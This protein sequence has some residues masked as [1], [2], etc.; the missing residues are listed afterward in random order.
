MHTFDRQK[1][2]ATARATLAELQT[3]PDRCGLFATLGDALFAC[4]LGRL[5]PVVDVA[6]TLARAQRVIAAENPG[7]GLHRGLAGLGF[8]LATYC[9]AEPALVEVDAAVLAALPSVPP[10]SLQSGLAGIALYASLRSHAPS[11]RRLQQAVVA[12][13][14][15]AAVRLAGGVVWHT[16]ADYARRRGMNVAAEPVL[17]LGMVHGV[18]GTLVGL[19]ALARCGHDRAAELARAGLRALSALEQSGDNRFG[20]VI[21]G[22]GGAGGTLEL[23]GRWCVGDVG[24]DRAAWLVANAVGEAAAAA[25]A[26]DRLRAHAEA[27]AA[28]GIA[29]DPTRYDLC[30]GRSVVAQV[31]LLMHRETREPIFRRASDR[32]ATV[33]AEKMASVRPPNVIYGRAGILL[34][35]LARDRDDMRWD[36]L[37]GLTL[38]TSVPVPP[39]A[40]G[41]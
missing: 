30:C 38:P 17:E 28:T 26:L 36:T 32:L 15:D 34:A 11:G 7:P 18:A 41:P 16:P 4:E 9:D 5:D 24:V 35:L 37:L 33:C 3:F 21:F 22:H 20:H 8:L 12:A 25:R 29:G 13:L 39:R 2:I 6:A 14:A 40:L 31:H 27:H 23:D 1:L 10:A 19:A